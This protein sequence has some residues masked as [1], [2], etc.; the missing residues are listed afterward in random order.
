M[1]VV[2]KAHPLDKKYYTDHNLKGFKLVY[3]S[4]NIIINAITI[5]NL[6]VM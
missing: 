6:I 1:V 2:F 4:G 5:N 3:V